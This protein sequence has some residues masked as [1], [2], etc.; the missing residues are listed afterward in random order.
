MSCGRKAVLSWF[1]WRNLGKAH[2]TSVSVDG[3]RTEFRRPQEVLPFRPRSALSYQSERQVWEHPSPPTSSSSSFYCSFF[4]SLLPIAP[5]QWLALKLGIRTVLHARLGL[6]RSI[7]TGVYYGFS[8]LVAWRWRVVCWLDHDWF[9]PHFF[10]SAIHKYS[11][12][13]YYINKLRNWHRIVS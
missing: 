12:T 10:P 9:H 4:S 3:L 8:Q 11:V 7:L 6:G 1:S 2:K 13:R 5:V